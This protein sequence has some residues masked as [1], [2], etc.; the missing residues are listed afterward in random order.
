MGGK[1]RIVGNNN[2]AEFNKCFMDNIPITIYGNDNH[3]IIDENVKIYGGDIY[4]TGSE[5]LIKIGKNTSIQG[6]HINTQEHKTSIII[7]EDCIFSRDIMIRTSDSH[8]L[9]CT[10][11]G[12]G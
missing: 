12:S 8:S 1:L 6:A 2:V 9:Y 10:N 11:Q 3:L 5:C 4:I 7:G